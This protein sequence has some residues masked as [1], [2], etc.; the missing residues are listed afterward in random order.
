MNEAIAFIDLQAQRR[1]LGDRVDRAIQRVLDHG[2]MILGQ[3]ST[4]S[5]RH[6]AI[7]PELCTWSLAPTARMRSLWP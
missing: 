1:R 6:S 3:K 4:R 5:N 7:S 2:H